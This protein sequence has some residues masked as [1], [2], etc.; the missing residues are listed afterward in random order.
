MSCSRTQRS[1]SDEA[2]TRNPLIYLESSN[3]P[4]SLFLKYNAWTFISGE[5][6][7]KITLRVEKEHKGNRGQRISFLLFSIRG[8][9]PL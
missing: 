4:L 2:R 3:P 9:K 6:G 7:E 8:N 5:Q 1:D